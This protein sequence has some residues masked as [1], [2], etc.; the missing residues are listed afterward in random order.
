LR[1]PDFLHCGWAL[2]LSG[3]LV[4]MDCRRR[5]SPV[6]GDSD[7]PGDPLPVLREILAAQ[8]KEP[9]AHS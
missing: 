8:P 5:R 9:T 3:S 6:A 7:A 4:C 1:L 2:A